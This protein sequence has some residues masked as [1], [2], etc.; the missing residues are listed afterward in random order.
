[1]V[2]PFLVSH[3]RVPGERSKPYPCCEIDIIHVDFGQVYGSEQVSPS[4]GKRFES[5][6]FS[7]QQPMLTRSNVNIVYV[8]GLPNVI[9]LFLGTMFPL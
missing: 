4:C 6:L 8:L 9:T 2:L 5:T 3:L 1:M 7:L